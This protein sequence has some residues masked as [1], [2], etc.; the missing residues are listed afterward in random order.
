MGLLKLF[1]EII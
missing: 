1:F